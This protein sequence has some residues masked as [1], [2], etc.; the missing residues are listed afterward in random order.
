MSDP[1]RR[2]SIPAGQG[3]EALGLGLNEGLPELHVESLEEKFA[4][5]LQAMKAELISAL[6]PETP[7]APPLPMLGE[8]LGEWLAFI[9]PKRV[10]PENEE[11]LAR[12]L[13]ALLL[14]DE[15]T[16]SAA[17]ISAHLEKLPVS[18]STR[19]KVRGV[20]RLV[21]EHA[22]AAKRWSGNN[23]FTL[24]R[25]EREGTREYVTL[26]D[27]ELHAVQEKLR[28]DRRREFRVALHLGLRPG[29]LFALRKSDVDFNAGTIFIHRSHGRDETKTGRDRLVP[30][31]AAIAQDVYEAVQASPSEIVFAAPDGKQQRGDTKMTRVIRTAMAS[32][33]IGIIEHTYKCRRCGSAVRI[34][35]GRRENVCT[36]CQVLRWPVPKVRAFRWYDLRHHAATAHRRAGADP[37]AISVALGHSTRGATTTERVYTHLTVADLHRELGRWS[38]PR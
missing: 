13:H 9:K 36:D 25:R 20:G 10:A 17:Q 24:V 27:N 5:Q 32:A 11:R 14:D 29:E 19:N 30:L 8:L 3:G 6:R 23:P 18:A 12:H 35:G 28:P 2:T 38:L 15:S 26:T 34:P 1:Y 33:G 16:L 7:E 22:R 37:L 21:V 4:A 31:L